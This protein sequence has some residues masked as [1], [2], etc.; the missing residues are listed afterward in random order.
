MVLVGCEMPVAA[1]E[2]LYALLVGPKVQKSC[3]ITCLTARRR[4]YEIGM[5]HYCRDC[6]CSS[7]E[8]TPEVTRLRYGTKPAGA[9]RGFHHELHLTDH[10]SARPSGKA[11][12]TYGCFIPTPL[13]KAV[14]PYQ[15]QWP[16]ARRH[17]YEH[18][19][20]VRLNDHVLYWA[21][22]LKCLKK[23]MSLYNFPCCWSALHGWKGIVFRHS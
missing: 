18:F 5:W 23:L 2:G 15:R 6:E 3:F 8:A 9:Q 22:V 4:R 19:Q 10:K 13:P 7:A 16:K 11:G 17:K 1:L 12:R 14:F 21:R 20:K